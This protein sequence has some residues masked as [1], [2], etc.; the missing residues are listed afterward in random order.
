MLGET[1]NAPSVCTV[2]EWV[3]ERQGVIRPPRFDGAGG[4]IL[5]GA[6]L[7]LKRPLLTNFENA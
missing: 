5:A 4:P 7:D 6:E 2:L 1:A 3:I